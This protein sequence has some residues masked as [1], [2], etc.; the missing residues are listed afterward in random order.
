MTLVYC[1]ITLRVH[2]APDHAPSH[3]RSRPPGYREAHVG[4]RLHA[5]VMEGEEDGARPFGLGAFC[6][7]ADTG[8]HIYG[9]ADPLALMEAM[10]GFIASDALPRADRTALLAAARDLRL[11]VLS[12]QV[13]WHEV[14]LPELYVEGTLGATW[15]WGVLTSS[16]MTDW[17]ASSRDRD[18]FVFT[19]CPLHRRFTRRKSHNRSAHPHCPRI[20]V[21]A[22]TEPYVQSVEF[23]PP[24]RRGQ[25][26]VPHFPGRFF[27]LHEKAYVL[28]GEDHSLA[29]ACRT[30]GV[31]P[32]T[33]PA[34]ISLEDRLASLEDRLAAL[35]SRL[36][37]A[38]A[39][40]AVIQR[41]LLRHTEIITDLNEVETLGP[42]TR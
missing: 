38:C 12:Q 11:T 31:A 17:G 32:P 13:Y 42:T 3:G 40:S 34:T 5:V 19:L 39:L 28:S 21:K 36:D 23:T 37:A 24:R 4:H 30:L 20:R 41:E 15:D 8:S 9:P 29:S 27:G 16:L 1:P 10:T 18:A 14:A 2:T 7:L 35:L 33:P 6:T 25:W 26:G 22:L